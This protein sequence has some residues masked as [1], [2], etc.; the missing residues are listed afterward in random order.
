MIN[1]IWTNS[2]NAKDDSS[3]STLEAATVVYLKGVASFFIREYKKNFW[4]FFK[5]NEDSRVKRREVEIGIMVNTILF[6]ISFRWYPKAVRS[7]KK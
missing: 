7:T 3:Q 6:W 5:R 1:V 4:V 2:D